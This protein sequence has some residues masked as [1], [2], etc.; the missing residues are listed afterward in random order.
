[1]GLKAVVTKPVHVS[2]K[3]NNRAMLR[4]LAA[5]RR[6]LGAAALSTRTALRNKNAQDIEKLNTMIRQKLAEIE[7]MEKKRIEDEAV[8]LS[9]GTMRARVTNST[10]NRSYLISRGLSYSHWRSAPRFTS[11]TISCG[12]TSN[13]TSVSDYYK[14]S[15]IYRNR[16]T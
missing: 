8:S 11:P 5:M 9:S 1:M 2:Y 10:R 3:T 12:G 14:V 4:A 15:D 6:P 16:Y 7:Q 13:T